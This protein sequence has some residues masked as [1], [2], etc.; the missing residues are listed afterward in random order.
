ML[1]ARLKLEEKS[2]QDDDKRKKTK[3][4]LSHLIW[5]LMKSCTVD[6]SFRKSRGTKKFCSLKTE[7]V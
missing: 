7:F 1:T 6:F 5:P 4:N 3:S 2:L